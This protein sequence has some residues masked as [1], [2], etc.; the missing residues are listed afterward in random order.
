MSPTPINTLGVEY[1]SASF[2]GYITLPD[3]VSD[4]RERVLYVFVTNILTPEMY[5]IPV[6]SHQSLTVN[7][8]TV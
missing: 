2:V 4:V 6:V 5:T 1:K 7:Y 3:R 8:Y